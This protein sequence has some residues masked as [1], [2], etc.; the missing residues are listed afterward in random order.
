ML[1]RHTFWL[2]TAAVLQIL[3]ATVHSLS[4]LQKMSG[5][6]DTEKQLI[7]LFVNYKMDM[8][9]GF[10]P[11]MY[12]LFNSMSACFALLYLFGGI[13]TLFL[14][15]KNL[16]AETMKGWTGICTLI[17]GAAFLIILLLAFLPPI[18]FTGMVFVCLCFAYATNHI[19]RFK[20]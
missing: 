15:N 18:I 6:N 4:F 14:V 17:F 9:Y 20:N 19:H 5:T 7:D 2:K 3:T 11:S 16:S 12:N 13:T 8:G 1:Q 10:H